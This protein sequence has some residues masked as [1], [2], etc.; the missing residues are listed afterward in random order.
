M[1]SHPLLLRPSKDWS[2]PPPLSTAP[3]PRWRWRLAG[4]ACLTIAAV[5]ALRTAPPTA[6]EAAFEADFALAA[7]H[8]PADIVG[9]GATAPIATADN[10]HKPVAAALTAPAAPP[11]DWVA[12]TVRRGDTLSHIFARHGLP[13]AD[14]YAT[15]QLP[16][17]APLGQIHPR[18]KIH[19]AADENGALTALRYP[20]DRLSTLWINRIDGVL[21]AEVVTRR[22][23][24]KLRAEQ[25]TITHSLLGAARDAGIDYDVLYGLAQIF[26]WQ[27]DFTRDI[28]RG[29]QFSVIF[30]Q[31]Y[32]D[33]EKIGN[34][35]IIAAQLR[36]GGESLR[37]IRHLDASYDA[38]SID[39]GP[40][41]TRRGRLYYAANGDGIQ[42]S[43][44]RSP[45]EFARVTSGFT[46][47]RL[48]PIH[49]T[50]RAHKGVD[51]GARRGTAVRTTSDGV[52][53]HIGR[54]G[55][56]GKRIVLR[57][58]LRYT[59]LYAHLNRYRARLKIGARVA[60]GDIIG[61]VGNTGW[62]TGPHLHY[63]FRVDGAHR[64]PLT[65]ALP[66]SPAIAA[67]H[68][69]AFLAQAQSWVAQLAQFDAL[70]AARIGTTP[71]NTS[72]QSAGLDLAQIEPRDDQLG[73]DG[74][75]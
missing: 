62:A 53:T 55:G 44:L 36:V 64:N 63:E 30:E 6:F 31:R 67:A 71:F 42:S 27:V 50:W 66:K 49:K 69:P 15:A 75:H 29:D 73:R 70:A 16:A 22:P 7:D 41:G 1:H 20:L 3:P 56:Y 4:V 51:Y 39:H 37:A 26:G 40:A 57:H 35:D 17:A 38:Q 12:A 9:A 61:Y 59:T 18:Q 32:L 8:L 19:L 5:Y 21:A 14:A 60:Q 52:V 54:S 47:R 45:L 28:R 34:G 11:P 74:A 25:A 65:V 48:H 68:K 23:Q 72:A 46:R 33:G 43:F 24:I 58:G 10:D 13:A 2:V